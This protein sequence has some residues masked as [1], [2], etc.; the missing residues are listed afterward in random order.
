MNPMLQS[1]LKG[2][3]HHYPKNLEDR[4]P[5]VFFNVMTLWGTPQLAPF[6][7]EL[8]L[9]GGRDSRQ[10][11]PPEVMAEIFFLSRFHELV[12]KSRAEGN[13]VWINEHVKRS[14]HEEHIEYSPAG[15]FKS[16]DTGNLR[17]IRLFIEADAELEQTNYLGWTPL[18]VASFIGGEQA[19]ILLIT[20]GADV[21][22]RDNLGYGPLHWACNQGFAKV[23]ELLV[24]KGAFV[25]A[26]SDK[27]LTPLLQ[28]ATS[29]H[30]DVVRF[31]I[32]SGA[33]V[34]D[35]DAEGW[36]PLHKAVANSHESV[37]DELMEAGADP[38][39]QHES[40]LT[41][42][43]ISIQKIDTVIMLKLVKRRKTL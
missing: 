10:G 14:L 25:N 12:M 16:I 42:V 36:T 43:D 30:A 8:F 20:A 38:N 4:F 41:S 35:A 9:V 7:S 5:K 39:S 3:E 26:K 32:L 11:F 2:R 23:A 22:A 21:N 18:M 19:A 29:G 15:F 1:L 31:L 37:V 33:V 17:A 34:N 28:A 40:G 13:E 24:Q 27:G 6:I